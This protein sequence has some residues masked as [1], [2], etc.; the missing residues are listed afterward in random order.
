MGALSTE[1]AISW[2]S[3]D[4]FSRRTSNASLSRPRPLPAWQP[5]LLFDKFLFGWA[6]FAAGNYRPKDKRNTG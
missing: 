1:M 5:Y 6:K 4:M 3:Q 2:E